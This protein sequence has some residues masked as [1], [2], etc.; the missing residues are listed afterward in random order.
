[1]AQWIL[2]FWSLITIMTSGDK[3]KLS[4]YKYLRRIQMRAD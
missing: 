1:M 3:Y 2:P 4:D